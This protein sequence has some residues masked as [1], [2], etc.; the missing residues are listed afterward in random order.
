MSFGNFVAADANREALEAALA[1][2][3]GK[4]HEHLPLLIV[5][6]V[7]TGKTHLLSAIAD[8]LEQATP[9]ARI[10]FISAESLLDFGDGLCEVVPKAD[11]SRSYTTGLTVATALLID[12]VQRLEGKPALQ[13]P[14]AS[15]IDK[16]VSRGGVVVLTLNA[17]VEEITSFDP[18]LATCLTSGLTCVLDMPA[19]DDRVRLL[20][21]WAVEMG[22][23][24]PTLVLERIASRMLPHLRYYKGSL[25]RVVA[26]ARLADRPIDVELADAVLYDETRRAIDDARRSNSRR[27]ALT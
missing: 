7:A 2:A 5:G 26:Y 19:A 4:G 17:P 12:D 23:E 3:A 22:V 24:V 8:R 14:L 15:T 27:G 20:H 16:A 13:A 9:D 11:G 18:Q 6:G 10:R 25:V 21:A 1:I